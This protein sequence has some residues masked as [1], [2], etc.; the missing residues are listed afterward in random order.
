M[1]QAAVPDRGKQEGK[2]KVEAQNFRAQ[3][4][5]RK[6]DGMPGPE[7]DVIEHPA[8]FPERNL[9]FGAA[10]E[11][12]KNSFRQSF[13]RDGAE[14]V[15]AHNSGR[16]NSTRGFAH[17]RSRVRKFEAGD[18]L[19]LA[20]TAEKWKSAAADRRSSAKEKKRTG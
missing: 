17:L 7:S 4:A 6:S 14:I 8:I 3:T 15:D 9:A 10:V 13:A 18:I 5:A 1:H 11:I 2:G 16:G 19:P 12:V 20:R